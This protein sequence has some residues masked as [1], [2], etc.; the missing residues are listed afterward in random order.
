MYACTG[1][2]IETIHIYAGDSNMSRD[3]LKQFLLFIAAL[4]SQG[5]ITRTWNQLKEANHEALSHGTKMI[6][7]VD[8]YLL[9]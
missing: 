4:P 6:W 9:H 3:E 1:Q 5:Q 2:T 8:L 7:S